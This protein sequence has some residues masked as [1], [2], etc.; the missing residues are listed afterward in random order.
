MW[1]RKQNKKQLAPEDVGAR[2][3]S[4]RAE[5]P[6][7][8]EQALRLI[9]GEKVWLYCPLCTAVVDAQMFTRQAQQ[10][11]G[12]VPATQPMAHGFPLRVAVHRA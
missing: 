2:C 11:P 6:I 3:P 7:N 8:Y 12:A 5:L 10:T 1:W 4:C 9:D